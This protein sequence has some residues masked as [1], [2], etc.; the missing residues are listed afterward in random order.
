MSLITYH[1]MPG[2]SHNFITAASYNSITFNSEITTN[3]AIHFMVKYLHVRGSPPY[4]V[5]IQST[6]F[7]SNTFYRMLKDVVNVD[8]SYCTTLEDES[9][10]YLKKC[11]KINLTGCSITDKGITHLRKTLVDLNMSYCTNITAKGIASL[12]LVNLVVDGCR[13][14]I[15]D[16]TMSQKDTLE[17]ISCQSLSCTDVNLDDLCNM[18]RLERIDISDNNVNGKFKSLL[19]IPRLSY[20]RVFATSRSID[21]QLF[22]SFYSKGIVVCDTYIGISV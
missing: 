3:E 10:K 21:Y 20:L 5:S 17:S 1:V 12:K 7:T 4:A 18:S 15:E 6:R 14:N 13:L 8:V 11:R 16:I 9:L 2:K 19:N 22:K